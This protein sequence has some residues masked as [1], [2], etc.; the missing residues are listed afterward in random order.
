MILIKKGGLYDSV[1]N[2]D[3]YIT[4]EHKIFYNREMIKVKHLVNGETII[5]KKMRKEIVYNV[6]LE[7]ET[8][9]KMIA[10]GMISETLDPRSEMVKLLLLLSEEDMTDWEKGEIIKEINKNMKEEH[11]RRERSKKN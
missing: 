10:N 6:L 7:G 9:G 4:E 1:P 3:T 2:E 11:K 5:R 8:S